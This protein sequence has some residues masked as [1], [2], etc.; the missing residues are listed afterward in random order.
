MVIT[1]PACRT[2]SLWAAGASLILL[3]ACK[4]FGKASELGT[5]I[6]IDKQKFH[7]NK[8]VKL[9]I[10]LLNETFYHFIFFSN[11]HLLVYF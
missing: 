2:V 3:V 9:I 7:T 4:T 1:G 10:K 11:H 5:N 6:T 8:S